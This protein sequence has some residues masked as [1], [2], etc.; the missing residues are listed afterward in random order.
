MR[1]ERGIRPAIAARPAVEIAEL[2]RTVNYADRKTFVSLTQPRETREMRAPAVE[3][4]TTSTPGAREYE[5]FII[6]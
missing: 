2:I 1:P 5:C 4:R 3:A 6:D